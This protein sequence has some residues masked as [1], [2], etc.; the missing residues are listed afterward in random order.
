MILVDDRIGRAVRLFGSY[1]GS[2]PSPYPAAGWKSSLGHPG[3]KLRA[4]TLNVST[5][6]AI[7]EKTRR[8]RDFQSQ[9][10]S[11]AYLTLAYEWKTVNLE[12]YR[13]GIMD[14]WQ[15]CVKPGPGAP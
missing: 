5:R 14:G 4:R 15:C 3:V 11:A 13:D 12:L 2:V 6:D 9:A 10:T 1:V 7:W 8:S